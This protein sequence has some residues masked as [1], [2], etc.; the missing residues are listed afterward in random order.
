VGRDCAVPCRDPRRASG[1]AVALAW[2]R[3]WA[4]FRLRPEPAWLRSS[5]AVVKGRDLTSSPGEHPMGSTATIGENTRHL[6][7]P[8]RWWTTARPALGGL[9]RWSVSPTVSASASSS[10]PVS[11]DGVSSSLSSTKQTSAV[12]LKG[13]P[14]PPPE[15]SG[16]SALLPGEDTTVIGERGC[17]PRVIGVRRT[18]VRPSR[19]VPRAAAER[20]PLRPKSRS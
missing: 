8:P 6:Q 19:S 17:H 10:E 2:S 18:V 5:S 15:E 13:R 1:S 14:Q 9:G 7:G 12:D 4:A 11:R 20:G 3:T 16:P